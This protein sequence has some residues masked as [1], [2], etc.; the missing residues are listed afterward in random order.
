MNVILKK[1]LFV[2]AFILLTLFLP[3]II[4]LMFF[5]ATNNFSVYVI[6]YG[7]VIFGILG[8]VVSCVR[9]MEKKIEET[10]ND[11]K[12]QNAAIAYKITN[13]DNFANQNTVQQPEVAYSKAEAVSSNNIPLN[14]PDPLV[15]PAEKPVKKAADDGFDDFK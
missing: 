10:M 12:M 5:D 3:G 1:L 4:L 15:M 8:Y 6:V 7:V 9:N 11:I 13:V 14:P 2:V